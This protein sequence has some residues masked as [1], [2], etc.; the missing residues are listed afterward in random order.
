MMASSC[1]TQF[2]SGVMAAATA[3]GGTIC[4]LLAADMAQPGVYRVKFFIGLSGTPIAADNNNIGWAAG[5]SGGTLGTPGV[6]G[7]YERTMYFQ[8]DGSD[9]IS[10]TAAV[11][12]G[13]VY[14]CLITAD[15]L[16]RN[17]QLASIFS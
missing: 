1:S 16:G 9:G 2:E 7:E 6:A 4:T 11:T 14:T 12:N 5:S 3:G 8:M 13:A 10:L 15:Y 17:G